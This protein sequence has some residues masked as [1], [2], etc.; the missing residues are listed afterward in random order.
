MMMMM[1]MMSVK[2]SHGENASNCSFADIE[3]FVSVGWAD[4]RVDFRRA[5]RDTSSRA[6]HADG[7]STMSFIYGHNENAMPRYAPVHRIR[8]RVPFPRA[9][10]P[11]E[12]TR[13]VRTPRWPISF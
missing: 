12:T 7:V 6:S 3:K 10:S 8:A 13:F 9:S 2:Q 4:D 5:P 1:M 11:D